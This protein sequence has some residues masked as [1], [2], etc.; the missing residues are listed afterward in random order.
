MRKVDPI[1]TTCI[2]MLGAVIIMLG[3]L[4]G[5]EPDMAAMERE[6]YC[7]RVAVYEAT[8]HDAQPLGHRDFKGVCGE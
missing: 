1:A 8:K 5:P 4:A 3:V 2:L 6:A 7:D